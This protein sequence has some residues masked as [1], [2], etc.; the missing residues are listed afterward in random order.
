MDSNP[1]KKSFWANPWVWAGC[2]CAV[3]CLAIPLL[4]F[5]LVGGGAFWAFAQ[6]DVKAQALE[7]V[8]HNAEAVAALG[9]PID[10]GWLFSG[11]VNLQNGKG[12][13][14]IRFPV[15]GPKG[16]GTVSARA[17]KDQGKWT[18]ER[19]TLEVAG[20]GEEIVIVGGPSGEPPR[21]EAEPAEPASSET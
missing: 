16:E 14:D 3:G 21:P 10:S 15:H 18:F 6:T 4:I 20:R 8:R 9:E 19:L 12:R 2:G 13:A 1:Q 7:Q 11:N 17:T 5:T